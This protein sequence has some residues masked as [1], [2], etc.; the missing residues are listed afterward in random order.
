MRFPPCGPVETAVAL[1]SGGV[2]PD[3]LPG[4][5][6]VTV[7][8]EPQADEGEPEKSG[9]PT[10]AIALACVAVLAVAVAVSVM[11]RRV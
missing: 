6:E 5:P 8:D 4:Q 9:V 1:E 11:R 3:P 2:L 10:M 7:P